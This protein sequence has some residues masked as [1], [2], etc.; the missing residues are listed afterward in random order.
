MIVTDSD[1]AMAHCASCDKSGDNVKLK[2]CAACKLVKYCDVA[3]QRAHRP[4]HK[5]ECRKRAAEL[6][7]EALF[8]EPPPREEC[9]ICFLTLPLG[10]S[11]CKY[12]VCCGKMLCIG[13]CLAAEQ[14]GHTECPFCRSPV[15]RDDVLE[16]LKAR[17]DV[18]DAIAIYQ[19]GFF[20]EEGECG[21]PR[22]LKTAFELWLRAGKLGDVDGYHNVA[23]SYLYGEG[24]ERDMRKARYY[25]EL[26]AKGGNVDSRHNLGVDE[27]IAGNYER[28]IRHWLISAGAGHDGSLVAIRDSY[29]QKLVTKDVFEKALRAHQKATDEM[30]S[31]QRDKAAAYC[32]T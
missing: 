7:D 29:A 30:K 15:T 21:L 25:W 18:G 28:A 1:V 14:E 19:F 12:Q 2:A 23:Q 32:Q 8:A 10:K 26:A 6:H 22:D 27:E 4:W 9:P 31:D 3:C 16:K 20:H 5:R 24:V 17:A 13:C 11:K